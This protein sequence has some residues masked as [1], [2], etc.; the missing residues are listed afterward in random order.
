MRHTKRQEKNNKLP[1]QKQSIE[2]NSE[3]TEMIQLSERE[4]K[5]TMTN[6]L[7]ALKE[8]IDNIQEQIS[9][10]SREMETINGIK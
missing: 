5:I 10:F 4:F 6:T 8:N 7:K 9:N 3:M 1:R 2:L